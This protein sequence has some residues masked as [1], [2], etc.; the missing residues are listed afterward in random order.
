MRRPGVRL[1]ASKAVVLPGKGWTPAEVAETSLPFED[2][3]RTGGKKLSCWRRTFLASEGWHTVDCLILDAQLP[4]MSGLELQRY[5]GANSFQAPVI[6]ATE[7]KDGHLAQ[8]LRGDALAFLRKPF[9][10]EDLLLRAVQCAC[11]R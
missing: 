10:D 8:A 9:E 11:M 7:D 3:V 5:L 4:G 1:T 6:F 2:T